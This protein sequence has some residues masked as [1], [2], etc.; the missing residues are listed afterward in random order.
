MIWRGYGKGRSKLCAWGNHVR[1]RTGKESQ[2]EPRRSARR[3]IYPKIILSF[4]LRS[5]G[6]PGVGSQV[7]KLVNAIYLV[8]LL[9]LLALVSTQPL[10]E[11]ND[12]A[13][14]QVSSMWLNLKKLQKKP[15]DTDGLSF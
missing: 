15:D 10:H 1:H 5:S 13:L 14:R 9:T 12:K 6:A 7:L 8:R 11:Q 4:G 3:L 2:G